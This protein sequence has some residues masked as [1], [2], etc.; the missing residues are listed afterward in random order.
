MYKFK[1]K[2]SAIVASTLCLGN[3]SKDWSTDNM[4]KNGLTGYVYDFS[5]NYNTVTVDD[6][7]D[8]HN[9]LMKKKS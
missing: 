4:K 2:E 6:I 1:A 7:K 3:Y 8:I 5:A 9:Y